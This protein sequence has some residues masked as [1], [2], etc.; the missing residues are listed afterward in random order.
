MVQIRQRILA[1]VAVSAVLVLPVVVEARRFYPDDPLEHVP[2]PINA[3]D[4]QRRRLSADFDY[5]YM[6][7]GKP[8]ERSDR[9]HGQYIRA[10]NANTL[11]EVP[12]SEWYTNRHARR[13]LTVAEMVRGPG[14]ATPPSIKGPWRVIDVKAEGVTP[15]FT[16]QD[17]EKRSYP[18]KFDVRENFELSTGADVIGSKFFYALG[19]NT[20]Q[21][22]VVYFTREQL[23][24]APN[25]KFIDEKGRERDLDERDIDRLLEDTPKTKDGRYRAVASL[26]ISGKP[27]GPFRYHGT[28]TDDPNDVIPHEHRRELRGLYV[29]AS[30]LNHND[31]KSLNSHDTLVEERGIKFIRH[32]LLDFS[33]TLGTDAFEPKSP[34]AGYVYLLDW[35]STAAHFFSLGFYIAPWERADYPLKHEAGRIESE[36][37]TPDRWKPNYFNPSF[38]NCLP[39]DAFWAAKQVMTFTEPEIRAMLETGQY[40]HPEALPYLTKVLVERQQKIGRT[41]FSRVLP[42]DKFRIESGTRLA[43]DDLGVKYRFASARNYNVKWSR[44]DNEAETKTAIAGATGVELPRDAA[45][46]GRGLYLAADIDAGEP[47]KTVTVFLRRRGGTWEPVAVERNW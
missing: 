34:R 42:L 7:F 5:F 20:P 36:V 29:F 33:A 8:G 11:G 47:G 4:L 27:V 24:V 17:A 41:W 37:F 6:T 3:G 26:F 14:N 35:P 9:G 32:Y 2:P 13:R 19:Y 38:E 40:T 39:D 15:G 23:V 28:R 43:F 21:N 22:Y 45:I 44:F 31:S 1:A 25:V 16:I 30:W 46:G 18:I 12:D 10:Q